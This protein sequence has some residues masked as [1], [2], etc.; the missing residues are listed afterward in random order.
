MEKLI[1]ISTITGLPAPIKFMKSGIEETCTDACEKYCEKGC[2]GCPVQECIT[3]L[4]KY[5]KTDMEPEEVEQ[6]KND[7]VFWELEAKRM[8]AELG[9]MKMKL[10][11]FIN[12][13]R[14][15]KDYAK[16]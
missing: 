11:S 5:Q 8:A 1:E 9:E 6:L 12:D 13:S 14:G 16:A 10:T 4:H 15:G 2:I 3:K 7:K